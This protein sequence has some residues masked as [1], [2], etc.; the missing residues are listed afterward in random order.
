MLS[1]DSNF[2]RFGGLSYPIIDHPVEAA[3]ARRGGKKWVSP[4]SE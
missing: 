4:L 2:V 3:V 1:S